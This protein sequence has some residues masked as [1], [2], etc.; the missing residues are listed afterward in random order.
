[1]LQDLDGQPVI[2]RYQ[3]FPVGADPTPYVDH[4]RHQANDAIIVA[5]TIKALIAGAP[6]GTL[7]PGREYQV[8]E[9]LKRLPNRMAYQFVLAALH[10][11]RLDGPVRHLGPAAS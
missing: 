9:Q 3:T 5:A 7:D 4:E 1:S 2:G 10:R 11:D 8:V 6:G